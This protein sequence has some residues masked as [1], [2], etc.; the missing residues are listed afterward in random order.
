MALYQVAFHPSLTIQYPII[1]G[2]VEYTFVL[3]NLTTALESVLIAD[4]SVENINFNVTPI[5]DVVFLISVS[6]P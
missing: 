1:Q 3:M 5:S 2:T 6:V 4:W